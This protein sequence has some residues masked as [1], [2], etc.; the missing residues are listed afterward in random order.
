MYETTASR[1]IWQRHFIRMG[2]T[3]LSLVSAYSGLVVGVI[4]LE[5][6][7]EFA[8]STYCVPL[9]TRPEYPF[10]VGRRL[11]LL[12]DLLTEERGLD[13]LNCQLAGHQSDDKNMLL[14]RRAF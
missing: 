14:A 3:A 10:H 9:V 5:E 4:R 11:D 2:G 7:N 6:P 12:K 13:W 1:Y 8:E